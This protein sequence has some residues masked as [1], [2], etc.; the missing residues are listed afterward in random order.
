MVKKGGK[1]RWV[2]GILFFVSLLFIGIIVLSSNSGVFSSDD[3]S[4]FKGVGFTFSSSESFVSDLS[5]AGA[6]GD[7]VMYGASSSDGSVPEIVLVGFSQKNAIPNSGCV[8]SSDVDCWVSVW[9][10]IAKDYKPE[11]AIVGNEFNE[12]SDPEGFVS[13]YNIVYDVI[14]EESPKTK[15]F[16]VQYYEGVH[17]FRTDLLDLMKIDFVGI[18]SYPFSKYA[19]PDLIPNNHYVKLMDYAS[20]RGLNVF[21]SE[22]GWYSESSLGASEQTQLEFYDRFKFLI[23]DNV[24]YVGWGVLY[25]QPQFGSEWNAGLLRSDGSKKLIYD[26]FMNN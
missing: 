19:S 4:Y 16:P 20:S 5:L 12:F 17:G 21:V 10:S 3:G 6:V 7:F 11:Y 8:D 22:I 26:Y 13:T 14:K 2:F 23:G 15:V 18:T 1:A 9:R 25:D 24:E